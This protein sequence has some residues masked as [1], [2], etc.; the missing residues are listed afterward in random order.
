MDVHPFG[1]KLK[2]FA[3]E[4]SPFVTSIT[5]SRRILCF[6]PNVVFYVECCVLCP[7]LSFVS[8]VVFCVQC[9]VL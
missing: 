5:L 1:G 9:C 2:H 6:M 4:P 3:M 7:I 8:K